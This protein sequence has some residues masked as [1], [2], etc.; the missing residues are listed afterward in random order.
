MF[1]DVC[2]SGFGCAWLDHRHEGREVVS[3]YCL[4]TVCIMP[5]SCGP[6]FLFSSFRR[7]LSCFCGGGGG[8]GCANFLRVSTSSSLWLEHYLLFC[9][10]N[11]L[12]LLQLSAFP[13]FLPRMV[14]L[15]LSAFT[16]FCFCQRSFRPPPS[17]SPFPFSPSQV[18]EDNKDVE[19]ELEGAIRVTRLLPLW[20]PHLCRHMRRLNLCLCS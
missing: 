16:F 10:S 7:V 1:L 11:T 12:G 19:D 13:T 3:K 15:L 8:G 2:S 4:V 14:L 6:A 5:L 9:F 20:S 18:S 17:S